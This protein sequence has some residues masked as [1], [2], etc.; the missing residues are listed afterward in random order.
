MDFL[1]EEEF[2]SDLSFLQRFIDAASRLDTACEMQRVAHSVSDQW[3]EADLV[4]LY[5]Q[6]EKPAERVAILIEDK[7][8]HV[9]S[10]IKQRDIVQGVRLE[11]KKTSGPDWTDWQKYNAKDF[12]AS[13]AIAGRQV[14]VRWPVCQH[15]NSLRKLRETVYRRPTIFFAD[16]RWFGTG[17]CPR[18]TGVGSRRSVAGLTGWDLQFSF[19][20]SAIRVGLLGR[21]RTRPTTY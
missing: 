3:G 19:A 11:R 6:L 8:E 21:L 4:V 18:K 10:L 12:R 15:H 5:R 14:W 13:L 7:F 9:F 17:C 1:L 2:S 16:G 20:F